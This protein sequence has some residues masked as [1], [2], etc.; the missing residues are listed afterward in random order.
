MNK[1]KVCLKSNS[2]NVYFLKKITDL[3]ILE[4]TFKKY[5]KILIITDDI[6]EKI[7]LKE[8]E[9]TMK[10]FSK[11]IYALVVKNGERSKSIKTATEILNYL[12]EN[13]FHRN[14]LIIALGGGVVGDLSGFVASTYLRGIDFIQMPTTLLAAVD[15]SIGGKTAVNIKFGKNLVGT[16][17][18]PK[19]VIEIIPIF[20]E[21]PRKLINEGLSEIVKYGIIYDP[22]I[23]EDVKEGIRER[24]NQ[25][26]WKCAKAKSEIVAEDEKEMGLRKILNYGHTLAH[27]IEECSGH[28]ISHGNAVAYGMIFASYLS[29]RIKFSEPQFYSNVKSVIMSFFKY[30]PLSFSAESLVFFMKKDKKNLDHCVNFIL[31]NGEKN[32]IF[33]FEEKQLIQYLNDFLENEQHA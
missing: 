25:I 8:I 2:Y 24:M 20:N 18:Q 11:N 6:V 19:A 4:D 27:S 29:T 13:E 3:V 12:A 28:H 21:L 9:N 23:L 17:H 33:S 15:A 30:V 5:N 14:D 26:V 31:S 7:Y 32:E 10:S 16:F 1:I 22:S